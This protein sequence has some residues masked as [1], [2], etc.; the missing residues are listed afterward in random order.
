M[1]KKEKSSPH[2]EVVRIRVT[3]PGGEG[4]RGGDASFSQFIVE[5]TP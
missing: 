5:Q 2:K 1:G 3:N 4:L